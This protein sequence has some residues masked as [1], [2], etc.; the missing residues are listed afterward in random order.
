MLKDCEQELQNTTYNTQYPIDTVFNAV[1]DY[2]DFAELDSQPLTQQQ[3][4][5]KAYVILN[6]T[7]HHRLELQTRSQ[8]NFD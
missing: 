1:E 4:I 6:K 5:A 3:I 2:V 8:E 7:R